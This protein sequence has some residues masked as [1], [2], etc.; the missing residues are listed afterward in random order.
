M[1]HAFMENPTALVVDALTTR[2]SG[3]AYRLAAL[4][5]I[6]SRADR[7]QPVT[8]GADKG[9]DT[10]DFAMELREP[11]VTPHGNPP[12]MAV[13]RSGWGLGS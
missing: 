3:H 5:L 9:Y 1:G 7:P 10:S 13:L 8:L 4:A 11:T 2:A 12:V 6:K